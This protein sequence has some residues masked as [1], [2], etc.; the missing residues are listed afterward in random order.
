MNNTR[1]C[2]IYL[3]CVLTLLVAGT[4]LPMS[5]QVYDDKTIACTDKYIVRSYSP[6]ENPDYAKGCFCLS[7]VVWDYATTCYILPFSDTDVAENFV[8]VFSSAER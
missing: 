3:S 4:I 2:V 7:V 5:A 6:D 8:Y 1:K